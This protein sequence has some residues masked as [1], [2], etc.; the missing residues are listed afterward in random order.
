MQMNSAGELAER[1]DLALSELFHELRNVIAAG[2][3]EL[4]GELTVNGVLDR[5][6]YHGA[7]VIDHDVEL[8]F[9]VVKAVYA[10]EGIY[11]ARGGFKDIAAGRRGYLLSRGPE[12]GDIADDYLAAHRE[13]RSEARG[14]DGVLGSPEEQHYFFSSCCGV[15]TFTPVTGLAGAYRP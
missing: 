4:T 9:R 11:L 10:G 14:A 7:A 12:Q 1:G 6:V 13:T 5:D 2:Q 3:L 8:L 15:H